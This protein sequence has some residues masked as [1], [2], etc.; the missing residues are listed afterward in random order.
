MTKYKA[1]HG[2]AE[3]KTIEIIRE[4]N[5]SIWSKERGQERK[6]TETIGYFDTWEEAKNFLL[7]CADRDVKNAR[8]TL[9]YY[10]SKYGNI[11]GLKKN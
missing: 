11:L 8:R 7:E 2:F 4:T 1:W 5:K 6:I 10:N 9:E 3:I